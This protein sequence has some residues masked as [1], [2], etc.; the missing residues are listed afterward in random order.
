MVQKIGVK[1][2][3]RESIAVVGLLLTYFPTF[4][5]M[6]GRWFAEDSYYSHGILVPF[7]SIFL[8]WQNKDEVK[9]IPREE[10]PWGFRLIVLGIVVHL[11]SSAFRVY[12]TSG[13][14]LL[15]VMTGFVLYFFGE[16]VLRKM[17]FPLAFLIFMVPLPMVVVTNMSFYLKLFVAN[18]ATMFLNN[19]RI[20]AVCE[21]S[22]IKMPNA[23]VIVND[24]CSGLRSLISLAALA[25]VFAYWM[26]ASLA[27]KTGLFLAAIPIAIF[28]N[29]CR[30]L[31]LSVISEI[32]GVQYA[33]GWI[34]DVSGFMVFIFAFY[35]MYAVGKLIE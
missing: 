7:V 13:F 19:M 27:K 18:I 5:W 9:N 11:F 32:W 10:S 21:G 20:A 30:V 6:W 15:I 16:R 17:A 29:V 35:F 24:V 34:H 2:Y 22:I 12:F 1:G 25:S 23:H 26:R 31:L 3:A 28:T 8:A 33:A 4:I 14:S